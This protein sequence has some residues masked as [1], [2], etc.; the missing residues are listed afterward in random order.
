MTLSHGMCHWLIHFLPA[1]P[2]EN[3]LNFAFSMIA[4]ILMKRPQSI[5]VQ[6]GNIEKDFISQ[7][8][9]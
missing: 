7:T 2:L 8:F 4:G 1:H 3:I 6:L 5:K 9:K